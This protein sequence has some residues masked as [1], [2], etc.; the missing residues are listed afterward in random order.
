MP[1]FI[2]LLTGKVGKEITLSIH[3]ELRDNELGNMGM[4]DEPHIRDEDLHIVLDG[5]F[6]LKNEPIFISGTQDGK[7]VLFKSHALEIFTVEETGNPSHEKTE[8][9]EK[10][11]GQKVDRVYS[12]FDTSILQRLQGKLPQNEIDSIIKGIPHYNSRSYNF[13]YLMITD[14][15]FIGQVTAHFDR[16][17]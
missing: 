9:L 8:S 3:I 16:L 4:F 6:G 15:D 13:D 1:N 14:P 10:I 5:V 17:L 12:F 7:P 11:D 2:A